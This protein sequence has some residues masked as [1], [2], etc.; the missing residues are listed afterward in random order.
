LASFSN[1]DILIVSVA[2]G[3]RPMTGVRIG[4]PAQKETVQTKFLCCAPF[5]TD[6]TNYSEVAQLTTTHCI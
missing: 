6:S 5:E 2:M 4:L 1:N 3:G